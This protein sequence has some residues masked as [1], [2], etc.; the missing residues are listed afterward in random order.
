M[1]AKTVKKL[2]YRTEC[3]QIAFDDYS[4]LSTAARAAV[5]LSA[6][7]GLP[8]RVIDNAR[9]TTRVVASMAGIAYTVDLS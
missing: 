7:L 4:N 8:V 9:N 3:Q 5:A 1:Y 2:P 6:E